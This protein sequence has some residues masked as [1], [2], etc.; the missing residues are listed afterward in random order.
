MYVAY[1]STT[2]NV[3]QLSVD[4]LSQVSTQAVFISPLDIGY[5]EGSSFYKINGNYYIFCYTASRC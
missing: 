4:G 1:G 2:I 3:A 5:I